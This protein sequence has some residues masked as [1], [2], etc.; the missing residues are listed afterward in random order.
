[1]HEA[2][3]KTKWLDLTKSDRSSHPDIVVGRRYLVRI[4]KS[5]FLGTFSKVWYGLH[6]GP[7][8]NGVGIGF[9]APDVRGSKWEAVCEFDE[10][11]INDKIGKRISCEQNK[12]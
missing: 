4:N 5:W 8:I 11:Y 1:M 12:E 10:Q 2:F 9:N 7:W 3:I 6:F